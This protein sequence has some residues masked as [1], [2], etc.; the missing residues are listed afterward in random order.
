MENLKI[1]SPLYAGVNVGNVFHFFW[2][3]EAP[4][5]ISPFSWLDTEGVAFQ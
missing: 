4:L 1:K 5:S 2:I 3:K